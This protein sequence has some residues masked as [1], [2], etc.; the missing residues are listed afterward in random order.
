[1][2]TKL[3]ISQQLMG[4]GPGRGTGEGAAGKCVPQKVYN[5][6]ILRKTL[7]LLELEAIS[8]IFPIIPWISY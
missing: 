2:A 3:V 4:G 8:G 5:V 6:W 7:R 1:M